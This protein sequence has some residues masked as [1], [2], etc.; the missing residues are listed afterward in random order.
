MTNTITDKRERGY[1]QIDNEIVENYQLSPYSGWLY[2]VISKYANRATGESFPSL[3]TLAQEANMSKPA[4]IKHMAELEK[5]NLITVKREKIN[6]K[7]NA[8]NRYFLQPIIKNSYLELLKVVNEVNHL[9]NEVDRNKTQVNKTKEKDS[10]APQASAE[11]AGDSSDTPQDDAQCKHAWVD[12]VCIDCGE[13]LPD[14]CCETCGHVYRWLFDEV[15]N[16]HRVCNCTTGEDMRKSGF[17]GRLGGGHD[18]ADPCPDCNEVRHDGTCLCDDTPLMTGDGLAPQRKFERHESGFK[19]G[20]IDVVVQSGETIGTSPTVYDL[21]TKHSEDGT[22]TGASCN[23]DLPAPTIYPDWLNDKHAAIIAQ[24]HLYKAYIVTPAI[25]GVQIHIDKLKE[26]GYIEQKPHHKYQ[27][28]TTT[29]YALTDKGKTLVD[30]PLVQ[31][32]IETSTSAKKRVA[33]RKADNASKPKPKKGWKKVVPEIKPLVDQLIVHWGKP[34]TKTENNNYVT[35]A[36]ELYHAN[37]TPQEITEIWNLAKKHGW[38]GATVRLCT[39]KL[40]TIRKQRAELDA[41]PSIADMH[42]C[43]DELPPL[44]PEAGIAYIVGDES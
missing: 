29:R 19:T 1:F 35:V 20:T 44:D 33:K 16:K 41:L 37:G 21:K 30:A 34:A 31:T 17:V 14:D 26:S 18:K 27:R 13:Q 4:V 25:N 36:W 15:G 3:N 8:V 10:S 42:N 9:V 28:K 11:S 24:C 7:K 5:R 40:G 22:I 23:V 12:R 39:N 32:T 6:A 38:D 2:C 43:A